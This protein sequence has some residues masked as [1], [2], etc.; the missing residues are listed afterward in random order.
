MSSGWVSLV[1]D[2]WSLATA[3][4]GTS[5]HGAQAYGREYAGLS[6]SGRS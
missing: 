6:G 4:F 5:C 2:H 3:L 1:T